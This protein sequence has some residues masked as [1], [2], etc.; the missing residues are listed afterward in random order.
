MISSPL[1][2]ISTLVISGV[3]RQ[4]MNLLISNLGFSLGQKME[5]ASVGGGK[6]GGMWDVISVKCCM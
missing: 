4:V 3:V 2:V 1:N 6:S 5:A